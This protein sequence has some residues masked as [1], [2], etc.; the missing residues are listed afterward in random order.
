MKNKENCIAAFLQI[1]LYGLLTTSCSASG[2]LSLGASFP[3]GSLNDK[4]RELIILRVGSL[5][6]S[7]YELINTILLL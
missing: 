4:D 1:I 7:A 5:S 2:Y 6:R 3:A